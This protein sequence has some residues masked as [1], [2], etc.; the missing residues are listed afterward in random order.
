[1]SKPEP[2]PPGASRTDTSDGTPEARPSL[3]RPGSWPDGSL[4]G[5]A[6]LR[7]VDAAGAPPAVLALHGFG[8]TPAEVDLLTDLAVARRLRCRAPLLPGHGTHAR[9]LA[10][11]R[12]DDWFGAAERALLELAKS[13]PVIVGGQSMGALLSLDLAIHHPGAVRALLVLANATRLSSPFP[14]LAL[15]LADRLHLP[16]L[17]LP[18][19]GGANILD[20]Q[21]KPFH[22]TYSAQPMHAAASL[23]RAGKR[24]IEAL[25]SIHCPTFI[26]HGQHDAVCPV[27]NAWLVAERISTPHVELLILPN[28]AHIITKD[29]DRHLLEQRLAAFL[30]DS[31]DLAVPDGDADHRA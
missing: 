2:S 26:A 4:T 5:N 6:A 12:Y 11:T 18:K 24:V 21:N 23:R 9:Q 7:E 31:L 3:W 17:A 10:K 27:D 15:A 20:E 30:D 1:V 13:G 22:L 28:S 29:R 8:C 16:D 25:P 19:F 14:D